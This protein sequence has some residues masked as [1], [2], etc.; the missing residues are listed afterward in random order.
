MCAQPTKPKLEITNHIIIYFI[1]KIK[2]K[3]CIFI[4]TVIKYLYREN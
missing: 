3:K 2:F 4:P 1:G